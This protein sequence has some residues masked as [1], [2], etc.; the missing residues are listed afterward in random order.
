MNDSQTREVIRVITN[1]TNWPFIMIPV[2]Q[3]GPIRELL[4]RDHIEH[5]VS[6]Y[7]ISLGGKTHV[8]FL[9]LERSEDASKA[10][11]ILDSLA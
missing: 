11:A 8:A 1:G 4:G 7:A 10:Q 9:Y 2:D 3:L 5:W 6:T